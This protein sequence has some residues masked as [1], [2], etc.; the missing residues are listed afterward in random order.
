MT[1]GPH[2]PTRTDGSAAPLE[3]LSF[4]DA[5]GRLEEIVQDLESGQMPLEESLKR[6]QEGMTLRSLCLARLQEAETKI[7]QVLAETE[8]A[9]TSAGQGEE[10]RLQ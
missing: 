5:L 6:F 7:E 10:L 4:E 3:D 9:E 1:A 8:E 2:A